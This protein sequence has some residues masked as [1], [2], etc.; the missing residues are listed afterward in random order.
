[1][2]DISQKHAVDRPILKCDF[3]R[4][5]PPSLNLVNGENHQTFIYIPRESSAFS[6]KDVYLDLDFNVTRRAGAHAR[7]AI[8]DPIK[9]VNLGPI[10]LFNKYRLTSSSVKE[11]K[12]I[13]IALVISLFNKLKPFRRDS[14]NLSIGFHRNK[15]AREIEL[16]NIKTIRGNYHVRIYLK[17]VFGFA[18]HQDYC[19]YDLGY[20]LTLQR[21]SENHVLSHGAGTDAEHLVLAGRDI[22]DDIILYVPHYTPSIS[23]QNS[24]KGSSVSRAAM[25][26]SYSPKSSYMKDV[27]TE[28]NW[29]FDVGVGDGIDI[30]I[31]VT[32]GFMQGDQFNQQHQS[33]DT[34][35]RP[36]I[37]K[38]K[39]VVGSGKFPDAGVNCNYAIDKYSQAYGENVSCF[40]HLAKDKILQPYITQKDFITAS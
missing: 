27:T 7:Y 40:R 13:N 32:V 15:E 36:S 35:Y 39:C 25:E 28:N 1:M 33:N 12:E 30:P 18:E 17:D 4:Y 6:L 8:G 16:T 10:A 38:A 37:V 34:F 2:F 9:I 21:N 23:N 5:T 20:K 29:T 24:M 3:I 11:L 26:S 14:D 31:Y 22:I 19:T